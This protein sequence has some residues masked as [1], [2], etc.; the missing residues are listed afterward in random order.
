MAPLDPRARRLLDLLAASAQESGG[1][2]TAEQRRA[3]LA[4]LAE[5]AADR[6]ALA[7]EAADASIPGGDGASLRVRSYRPRD[8]ASGPGGLIVYVHGGGWVGGDLETHD[9]VCRA[10]ANASQ[11]AVLAVDYRRA[12]EHPAPAAL[13]DVAAA[14]AWAHEHAAELG[15]DSSLIG[16]AG[17]S[18]GGNIAAAACLAVRAHG[19]TGIAL[20]VLI[21]PIL[22]IA[23]SQPSRQAFGAGYFLDPARFAQDAADYAAGMNPGDQRLSPLRAADLTGLPT[24]F[25]HVAEYD[26]FRDEGLAFAARLRQCGTQA[27]VHVHP[28]M[29]HYFYALPRMIPYACTALARIGADIATALRAG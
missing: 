3:S 19:G 13:N 9:G 4:Q 17:D 20:L 22:E 25:I 14:L 26:P 10:I 1:P 23:P 16:L 11:C 18:A 6:D 2:E 27:N 28:G 29:I 7:V 12:P 15:G 21:C 5:L 24:T 8:Q